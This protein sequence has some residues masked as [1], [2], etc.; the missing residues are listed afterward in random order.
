MTEQ[1]AVTNVSDP[2]RILVVDDAAD[3]RLMLNLRLQREGYT[4]YAAGSGTEALEIVR[5]RKNLKCFIE[6]RF[7]WAK[8]DVRTGFSG[9]RQTLENRSL[10]RSGRDAQEPACV[11]GKR[12]FVR[13]YNG[14]R[15][16]SRFEGALLDPNSGLAH[17]AA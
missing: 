12:V 9:L 16:A 4:V 13:V 14:K 3:T 5:R 6:P 8:G 7:A 10:E 1:Q 2:K 17:G 11:V 15:D